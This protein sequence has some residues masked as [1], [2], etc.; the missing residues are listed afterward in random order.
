MKKYE[1]KVENFRTYG[2][3]SMVLTNEHEKKMNEL[4][5]E[6]WELVGINS[7]NT[8]RNIIGIFKREKKESK[9]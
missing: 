6:G 4:G 1:Y 3:V 8:G 9:E 2:M 7:S 5:D